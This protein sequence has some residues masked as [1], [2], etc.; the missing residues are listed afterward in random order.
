MLRGVRIGVAV[1]LLFLAAALAGL[2]IRSY[3]WVTHWK[4]VWGERQGVQFVSRSGGVLL[5]L[6][7]FE[8]RDDLEDWGPTFDEAY[9]SEPRFQG[10]SPTGR[11]L[12][13]LPT[14]E[15]G[16]NLYGLTGWMGRFPYWIAILVCVLLAAAFG[17]RRPR[18]YSLKWFFFM[19]TLV[20]LLLG[21]TLIVRRLPSPRWVPPLEPDEVNREEWFKVA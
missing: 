9:K 20:A 13:Q 18:N 7:V 6:S 11:R 8:T 14:F 2:W 15:F 4:S 12:I 5:R 21:T 3:S 17:L 1:V 16:K 10:W 19:F